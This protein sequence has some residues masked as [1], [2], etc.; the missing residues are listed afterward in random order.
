MRLSWFA[1]R[2]VA[3]V[4]L[5]SVLGVGCTM[6]GEDKG[7]VGYEGPVGKMNLKLTLGEGSEVDEIG[8]E[9]TAPDI[10]PITGALNV[11]GITGPFGA[12]IAGIPAGAARTLT[13]TAA[14]E[15]GVACEGTVV[16]DVEAD[17]TT[18]VSIVLSCSGEG[19]RGSVSVDGSVEL[20]PV[21]ASVSAIPAVAQ[22]GESIYL[23]VGSASYALVPDGGEWT[24]DSGSFSDAS[25]LMT[26]YVCEA[27]G[28]HT[29]TLNAWDGIGCADTVTVDV[30]C[31]GEGTGPT[32]GDG[33]VEGTE[34]CDGGADCDENC[35]LIDDEPTC[36]DGVVEGT[37]E[38]D[39]G[40]DCDENCNLIESSSVATAGTWLSNQIAFE[41]TVD[42]SPVLNGDPLSI[43]MVLLTHVSDS[44]VATARLCDFGFNNPTFSVAFSSDFEEIQ[45]AT[46][47]NIATE[48][49]VDDQ[50]PISG[51]TLTASGFNG[52]AA[53]FEVAMDLTV[54]VGIDAVVD[55]ADTATGTITVD[56]TADVT[57]FGLVMAAPSASDQNPAS[58]PLTLT[59]VSDDSTLNCAEAGF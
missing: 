38:C 16:F 18:S 51:L 47:V 45:T 7:A 2:S 23:S 15:N 22:V 55:S 9:V 10:E 48:V 35:E 11:S 5:L 57:S 19:G 29:L 1:M 41:T 27:P 6:G 12:V 49:E 36:G 25:Q 44:G 50:F 43:P 8:Y 30:E 21:I 56:A 34:E 46:S 24:A 40:A 37:E 17:S 13:L 4:A 54:D 52:S 31:Q 58:A 20:C 53:G 33:V 32:C 59:K 39:G 42:A 14:A 28:V 3:C 26:S